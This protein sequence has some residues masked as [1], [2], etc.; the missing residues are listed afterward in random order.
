[1]KNVCRECWKQLIVQLFSMDIEFDIVL[2]LVEEFN[3]YVGCKKCDKD[4]K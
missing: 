3:G 4:G 2:K 1:M